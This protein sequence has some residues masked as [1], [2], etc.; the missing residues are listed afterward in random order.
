[1]SHFGVPLT[2]AAALVIGCGVQSAA[3][4]HKGLKVAMV[5]MCIEDGDLA[6]NITRA[7]EGIRQAAARKADLICIPEAADYGW[8]YQY[9]RRDAFTIPGKYTRVLCKL[10]KELKVWICAGCLEKADHG[11]TYNSAIIINRRGKIVL[12]H[13]KFSTLPD[14]TRELYDAGNQSDIKTVDTE[15]GRIGLTICADNFDINV[16]KR[17]AELGAWLL[18]APHGFAAPIDKLEGNAHSFNTH[19]KDMAKGSGLWVIGANCVMGQIASGDWKGW[20][21]SGRSTV[22]NPAGE[23]FAAGKFQYPDLVVCDIPAEK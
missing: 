15:F 22:A 11:K 7:E 19:I 1:L 5:Q 9:A 4:P 23:T 21:H 8:L 16:P 10:A 18:I 17:V 12:K 20:M 14:L 3:G 2:I 13:R 6:G